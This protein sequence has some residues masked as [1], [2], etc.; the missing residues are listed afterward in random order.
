MNRSIA[1]SCCYCGSE[2][3][4]LRPYGPG[5]KDVCFDCA[6]GTDERKRQTESSFARQLAMAGPVALIDD[7]DEAGP[8]PF[9]ATPTGDPND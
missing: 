2:D 5:G 9:R 6:M 4:E 3:E 8:V 1:R 7:R